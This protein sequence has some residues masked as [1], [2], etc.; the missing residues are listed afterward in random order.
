MLERVYSAVTPSRMNR[1]REKRV[2]MLWSASR[3]AEDVR[4][5]CE[6]SCRLGTNRRR[7]S[8]ET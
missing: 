5:C 3:K 7:R 8:I 6:T 1:N 2:S 4:Y